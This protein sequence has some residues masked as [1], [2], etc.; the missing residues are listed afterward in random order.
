VR[1]TFSRLP[2]QWALYKEFF[3]VGIPGMMNTAINNLVVIVLTGVAGHL[4]RDAALGYAM[5]A[6]LEYIMIPL[7]FGFGTALVAMVGTNW[8]ANHQQRARTIAWVGAGTVAAACGVVGLFFALFPALWMGLFTD[9]NEVIRVGTRYLQ[10]VGPMYAL[11][12][13]GMAIYF[14]MQGVGNVV[15]AVV[16]NALRL[17]VGAGGALVAASWLGGGLLGFFAAIACGFLLYGALNA[18]LLARS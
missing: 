3:R 9:Q 4:G 15:P 17:L 11:H 2:R 12:G 1:L 5:G 13:L 18:Y 14:A 10:T 6:R 7:A 8:G 16:A